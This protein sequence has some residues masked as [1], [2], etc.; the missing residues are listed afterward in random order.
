MTVLTAA[1]K[2][3]VSVTVSGR[4]LVVSCVTKEGDEDAEEEPALWPPSLPADDS[5]LRIAPEEST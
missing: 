5:A 3:A 4:G 2:A 1:Q